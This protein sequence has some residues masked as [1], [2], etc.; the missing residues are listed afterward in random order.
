MN[1]VEETS[2]INKESFIQWNKNKIHSLLN[3]YLKVSFFCV[4]FHVTIKFSF[5]V[6]RRWTNLANNCSRCSIF[7]SKQMGWQMSFRSESSSTSLTEELTNMKVNE[8]NKKG[9]NKC[10]SKKMAETRGK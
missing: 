3:I 8:L 6:K 10:K 2:K 5:R 1:W 7:V 9:L 4:G